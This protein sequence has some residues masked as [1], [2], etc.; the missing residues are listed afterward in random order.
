[1]FIYRYG[2]IFAISGFFVIMSH[3]K[4]SWAA[5]WGRVKH[6][7][8]EVSC[9][10]SC[11]SLKGAMGSM[12]VSWHRVATIALPSF[13]AFYCN[14]IVLGGMGQ[15]TSLGKWILDEE[16]TSHGFW[17]PSRPQH[18]S[19]N[20]LNKLI[21]KLLVKGTCRFLMSTWVHAFPGI[22]NADT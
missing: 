11:I 14:G 6:R 8:P 16:T 17:Y 9:P 19:L 12:C 1:M 21:W 5:S 15:G 10:V 13:T 18:H 22:C 7:C 4:G 2:N 20:L 3:F